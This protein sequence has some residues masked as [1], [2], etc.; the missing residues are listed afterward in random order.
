MHFSLPCS[1]SLPDSGS[2]VA[3]VRERRLPDPDCG[4]RPGRAPLSWTLGYGP[5]VADYSRYLPADVRT[6]DTFWTTYFGCALGSL[7]MMALGAMLAAVV[8][9]AL[10]LD[11][12]TAIAS[13]FGP[14]AKAALLVLVLGVI[15]YNVLCLYS[16]YMSTT[17][18]FSGFARMLQVRHGTKTLIMAVLSI[19]ACAIATQTQ[20]H[21]DTFFADILIG[22]LYL[23]IPWSAINLADYYLVR[24]GRYNI[25]D[26]YDARGQYGRW[27]G[28]TM[29]VY[30]VSIIGTVPFMKLSFFEGYFAR[31]IGADVSWIAGLVLAGLL[32]LVFNWRRNPDRGMQVVNVREKTSLLTS[33]ED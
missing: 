32:Y 14:W 27:N 31:L 30:A 28:K 5:Y 15:Q 18:I 4:H 17:T 19:L 21:F 1:R 6:R 25:E 7:G 20:Y 29:T 22:Q 3:H 2:L 23:L 8:P 10:N 13:L 26:L 11:P 33:T 24:N 16:A 12:G 9:S